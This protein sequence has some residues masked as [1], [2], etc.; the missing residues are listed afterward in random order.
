MTPDP[1]DSTLE[2]LSAAYAGLF[3]QLALAQA[4]L[5]LTVEGLL[6]YVVRSGLV[7]PDDLK[8]HLDAYLEHHEIEMRERLV[9]LFGVR[10]E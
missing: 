1:A 9:K 2:S 8:M 10:V 7:A 6:D 4:H 5:T 3:G